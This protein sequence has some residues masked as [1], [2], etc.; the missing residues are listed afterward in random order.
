ML[1]LLNHLI[2]RHLS[3]KRSSF[4]AVSFHC[5]AVQIMCYSFTLKLSRSSHFAVDEKMNLKER[6]LEQKKTSE[7]GGDTRA[8]NSF[9][10]RQDTVWLSSSLDIEYWFLFVST[11]HAVH[12]FV[13]T[14][15]VYLLLLKK[16][17]CKSHD[18][19]VKHF[20]AVPF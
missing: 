7:I 6:R 5:L 16:Y 9:Y 14:I 4:C 8:W 17:C 12:V 20:L 2:I 19:V 1:R 11:Q 10:M 3:K 13:E 18:I 15:V